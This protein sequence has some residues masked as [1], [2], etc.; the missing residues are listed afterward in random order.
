VSK[1]A[2]A[3]VIDTSPSATTSTVRLRESMVQ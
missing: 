1:K 2:M 3:S